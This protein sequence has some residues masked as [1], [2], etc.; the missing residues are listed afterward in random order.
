MK[1]LT[2]LDLVKN[3]LQNA[4]IQNLSTAPSSPVAG[5]IYYSTTDNVA[6]MYNGSAWVSIFNLSI[7][8]L[9]VALNASGSKIDDDNLSSNV[10]NAI[11]NSHSHTNKA[12]LDAVTASYTT[13]EQT[14]L[15]GIATGANNYTHPSTHPP[16]IIV[17]D[18]SNRFVTDTEKAT[19]NAKAGT[20]MA[21]TSVNGLMASADK[22][23]LDGVSTGANKAEQSSTNGNI[24]IDGVEKVVY[25]HPGS[26]TNPHG[27]TKADV[28]L[29]SAEN[30]S[31]ATIRG[32]LTSANVTT[33]LSFT[34]V[35]NGG[36]T[37]E[38]QAGT[39]AA[40][41]VATG[42][43]ILYF[44]TDT[45]KIWKDTAAG[46]WT[47][48]GG[49]DTLG[50][51][52]ITGKPTEFNPTIA[53]ATVL[54]GI[55][56]GAN[57]T[58]A[59]DGTLNAN[60]NPASFIRKQ[61]RFTVGAGQTAFTL[62]KGS[63]KP[64][65]GAMTWFLDGVKQDDAAMTETS[66]TVITMPSGLPAGA[67]VMFEW[68]EV[69]NM[70]P[71]PVHA[72]EHLTG[73]VDAIPV[74]TTTADGLMSSGDKMKLDGIAVGANNYTHPASHAPSIITQ[75]ANNR[76]VTD[77][78]KSTWNGKAGTAVAT[79]GANGL[80]SST[81]KT[82]LDGVA[83]GANNY[84]HPTGDGNLHVPATSTTNNGKVLKAGATAG[85]L[86]WG[87][88]TA[89]DVGALAS[90]ATATAATK[91]ATA[92]TVALA[93]DVTGSVS[94]DGSANVS[95]TTVVADDSHNHI[96]GNVDGLQVA[97]DAKETPAGAQAKAD[98]A[99][100]T[101]NA[102]T[103]TKVAALVDTAPTALDTLNELAAALGDDP[104]FATTMT[105]LIGTKETPAGAQ[106]KVD[107]HANRTDNPHGVTKTQVGLGSV[108]N[109]QQATKAEFNTHN[110]DGTRHIT[111]AERTAWNS[112]ITKYAVA[113]GDG[114][115]TSFTVT[116]NLGTQDV[117]VTIRESASP[118]AVVFADIQV[119][120]ANAIA[121]LF[122]TA[123]TAGQYRVVVT[124]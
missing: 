100:A 115:A 84:A 13:A 80:M 32:E 9:L 76:F 55:K 16:S 110:A 59:A 17:Q 71:Y 58:V 67:E 4:R 82:K 37:P 74:A 44:A 41:P 70:D 112:K 27:T 75:D 89:A 106:T 68:L 114:T 57:L 18:A 90:G 43:G 33:A 95:I 120:S 28:G 72:S 88:L 69:I 93:G 38:L 64:N 3:E 53:T 62:T 122:A 14:K 23:K 5:Q 10:N 11:A 111:A 61:E 45:K 7:S 12:I 19:W 36:S 107:T 118:Y 31:S 116:H 101:A 8:E 39:E 29:G 97:L 15:S 109:I 85:S 91:L 24:K 56:V 34:P 50:W 103:D 77:T 117:T 48:M 46:T 66:S 87:T 40:R 94:F 108:D 104:N 92:R 22:T 2:N 98:A 73:G 99:V 79:T 78:E 102:Y 119:T 63:Y 113:I 42:S 25:T 47:Q 51:A 96:I 52:S 105:N 26:G 54:G 86:S 124:G 81:D 65:S 1:F 21:T 121:V 123:P 83:T 60:D 35:K 20:A 30:K 6:Y 49:Q